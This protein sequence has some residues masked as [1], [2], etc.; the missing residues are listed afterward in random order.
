MFK[1]IFTP[2]FCSGKDPFTLRKR[3]VYPVFAPEQD[4]CFNVLHTFKGSKI[5]WRCSEFRFFFVATCRGNSIAVILSWVSFTVG[6]VFFISSAINFRHFSVLAQTNTCSVEH[7]KLN[8][9]ILRCFNKEWVIDL[10]NIYGST[11]QT[12]V[13]QQ[14]AVLLYSNMMQ[15]VEYKNR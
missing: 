4:R 15:Q 5:W 10:F 9:I 13:I 8:D 14:T 2:G 3:S 12:Q 6:A 1:K 11:Q 7:L